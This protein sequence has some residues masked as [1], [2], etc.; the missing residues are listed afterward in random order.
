[1][2]KAIVFLVLLCISCTT[3]DQA[4][5]DPL[6][7]LPAETQTGANTFGCII[8]SQVFY[9][10]DGTGSLFSPGGKGLILWG[11]PSIPF[12]MGNYG[13]FEIRKLQDAKP[14]NSMIIH[15]Q[16]LDQIKTGDYIWHDSNFQS[17]I[18]GLMQNYVYAKIFDASVNGWRYYGS[19][20]NSGKVTITKYN[21]IIS[22][23]FSGKLKLQNGTKEIDIINGRF[24][25]GPGLGDKIFP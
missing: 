10:R 15:L 9:P 12:G 7:K 6:A 22:G 4:P 2:K 14:A 19:Y 1:M 17:S 11:D 3:N 25:I 21:N 5:D 16:G 20:E 24:D 13:E 8:N 23:N 18:D